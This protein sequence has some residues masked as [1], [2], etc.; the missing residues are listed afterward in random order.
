MRLLHLGVAE[1]IRLSAGGLAAAANP[2]YSAAVPSEEPH[3]SSDAYSLALI[4]CELLTGFHPARNLGSRKSAS[5]RRP[6]Q[7]D[8]SLLSLADRAVLLRALHADANRRSPPARISWPRWTPIAANS[9]TSAPCGS[10]TSPLAV[11]FGGRRFPHDNARADAPT[12][13]RLLVAGAAADLEV[14]EYRNARYLLR[15]GCRL[16]HQFFALA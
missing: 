11:R 10:T 2:R 12:H 3:L 16:E 6:T 15:P 1:L 5:A 14:C 9:S 8:L 4:Y 13:Q 7:P